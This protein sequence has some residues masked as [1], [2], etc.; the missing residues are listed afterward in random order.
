LVTAFFTIA[1][2]LL[3]ISLVNFT[4]LLREFFL[5]A[6]ICALALR[7]LCLFESELM[8]Q[9]LRGYELDQ[10]L[11][12]RQSEKSLLDFF[13]LHSKRVA[14]AVSSLDDPSKKHQ[15]K[16][17]TFQSKEELNKELQRLQKEIREK[18]ME[19]AYVENMMFVISESSIS[20]RSHQRDSS[21][22][23]GARP[24][25]SNADGVEEVT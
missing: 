8:L 15:R 3:I 4:P 12:L 20:Q 10:G 9:L 14:V 22:G 1:V 13:S 17:A 19:L 21:D 5:S 7:L 11:V 18:Q 6:V 24:L 16:Y 25:A 23:G 2:A